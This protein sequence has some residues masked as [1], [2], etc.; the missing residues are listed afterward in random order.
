MSA[1]SLCLQALYV[2]TTM[3][4]NT[5]SQEAQLLVHLVNTTRFVQRTQQ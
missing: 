1:A 2:L 5:Q 4:S 3:L